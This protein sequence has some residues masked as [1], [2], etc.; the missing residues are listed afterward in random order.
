MNFSVGDI[1]VSKDGKHKFEVIYND[2]GAVNYVKYLN[3]SSFSA[4]LSPNI[5]GCGWL[6]PASTGYVVS[7]SEE[8]LYNKGYFFGDY[9]TVYKVN[10]KDDMIDITITVPINNLDEYEKLFKDENIPYKI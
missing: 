8:L 7:I 5:T 2:N 1:F 4:V 3:D 10:S 9:L 6:L